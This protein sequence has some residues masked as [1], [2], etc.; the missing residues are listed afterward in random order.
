M[1]KFSILIMAI[2]ETHVCNTDHFVKDG[3]HFFFSGQ[4]KDTHAGVGF[5][6]SPKAVNLIIGFRSLSSRLCELTLRTAP[7]PTF[8]YSIYA[9]SQLPPGKKSAR[10]GRRKKTSILGPFK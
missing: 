3:F 6:V 8:L 5:I 2:Q 9:P 4:A 1:T 7:L 10:I